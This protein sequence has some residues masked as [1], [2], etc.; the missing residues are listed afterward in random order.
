MTT[1]CSQYQEGL[2]FNEVK[3]YFQVDDFLTGTT[4][5]KIVKVKSHNIP[6]VYNGL[7]SDGSSLIITDSGNFYNYF[8]NISIYTR[9]KM[10]DEAVIKHLQSSSTI[11]S[12][13]EK[14]FSFKPFPVK[15]YEL[16]VKIASIKKGIHKFQ[17][18]NDYR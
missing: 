16:K 6:F 8:M 14:E 3:N 9:F 10:K 4:F 7:S 15:K 1:L 12:E 11:V 13:P 2:V 17:P 18:F 5:S